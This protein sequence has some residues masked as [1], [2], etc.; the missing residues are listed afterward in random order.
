[1]DAQA[2]SLQG[3]QSVSVAFLWTMP[4]TS[5]R[6]PGG[7]S[8]ETPTPT[9][10]NLTHDPATPMFRGSPD[11]QPHPARMSHGFAD[12]NAATMT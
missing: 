10:L 4:T 7:A 1:M 2:R 3:D 9:R 11:L 5:R 12:E 8:R 6:A